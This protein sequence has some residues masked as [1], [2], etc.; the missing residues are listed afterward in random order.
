MIVSTTAWLALALQAPHGENSEALPIAG[1]TVSAVDK[2]WTAPAKPGDASI[3]LH[4][5]LPA[6]ETK[7]QAWFTDR[8]G[9]D[10]AGAFYA[11]IRHLP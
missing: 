4:A 6:G 3:T 8:E 9:K 1:A 5:T 7:L 10:L 2:V 11:R